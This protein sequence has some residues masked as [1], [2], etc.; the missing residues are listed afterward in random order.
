MWMSFNII[1]NLF[2]YLSIGWVDIFFKWVT[3]SLAGYPRERKYYKVLGL[4]ILFV[5][6]YNGLFS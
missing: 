1:F 3:F 5:S 2:H 6:V 4:A